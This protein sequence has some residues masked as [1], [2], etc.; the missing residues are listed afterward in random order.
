MSVITNAA[1]A[2]ELR[3]RAKEI[4]DNPM[5]SAW[6]EGKATGYEEA[7]RMILDPFAWQVPP[8]PAA[9]EPGAAEP[10]GALAALISARGASLETFAGFVEDQINKARLGDELDGAPAALYGEACRRA[11]RA[12]RDDPTAQPP[13]M[14]L[15]GA[16]EA[17]YPTEVRRFI[18]A[19]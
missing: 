4:N 2:A 16:L 8:G 10:V 11:L 5:D 17:C 3:R 19:L 9:A 7:A 15:A 12:A 18:E 6:G 13:W 14:A 1:I